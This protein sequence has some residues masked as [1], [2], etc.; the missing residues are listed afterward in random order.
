MSS[1]QGKTI[2]LSLLDAK[3]LA[4]LREQ[5]D[6]EVQSLTQSALTLQRAAGEFGKSGKAV[7]TL[8]EQEEGQA[9]VWALL[10]YNVQAI[11]CSLES[12]GDQTRCAL[13]NCK[14]YG[15]ASNLTMTVT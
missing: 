3:E 12:L 7:E 5:L 4:S 13:Q 15:R 11:G 10:L 1:T 2:D 9:P 6:G 14:M 8:A